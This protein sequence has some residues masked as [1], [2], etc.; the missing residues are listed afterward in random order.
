MKPHNNAAITTS[1]GHIQ[2]LED[3]P[4]E[5]DDFHSHEMISEAL[6]EI[7]Q[8]RRGGLTVGLEGKWGSGKSTIIKILREKLSGD[9]STFF[10]NF[11]AWVH[12]G[13]P[14]RRAFLTGL[15]TNAIDKK[16]F[17]RGDNGGQLTEKW[18]LARE[19][20]SKKIKVHTKSVQP[21][22]SAFGKI[23]FLSLFFMPVGASMLVSAGK[24]LGTT[25]PASN[26]T[27]DKYFL[28]AGIIFTLLP[29]L[30]CFVDWLRSFRSSEKGNSLWAMFYQRGH[31]SELAETSES[32]DSTT[33]EFQKIFELFMSDLLKPTDAKLVIVL[34]NLDRITDEETASVWPVLRSFVD[35]LEYSNSNWFHRLWVIIPYAREGIETESYDTCSQNEPS[36]GEVSKADKEKESASTEKCDPHFLDKIFQIKFFVPAPVLSN[37]RTYLEKLL[38]SAFGANCDATNSHLIYLLLTRHHGFLNP[39]GPRE[40]KN[41]INGMVATA[42]QWKFSVPLEHQAYYS[43]L[44]RDRKIGDLRNALLANKIKLHTDLLGIEI[45]RSLIALE[46]N[47]PLELA[48]QTLYEPEIRSLLSVEGDSSKLANRYDNA[49]FAALFDILI[50][51]ILSENASDDSS[52]FIKN[53]ALL[54][55]DKPCWIS[56]ESK[57]RHLIRQV[58]NSLKR[59]ELFPLGLPSLTE[60]IVAFIQQDH[61]KLAVDSFRAVLAQTWGF[62]GPG[63]VKLF[64]SSSAPI[65]SSHVESAHTLWSNAVVREYVG[66]DFLGSFVLPV[67]GEEY[68]RLYKSLNYDGKLELLDAFDLSGPH[69]DLISRLQNFSKRNEPSESMEHI[70]ILKERGVEIP[71]GV[72][73]VLISRLESTSS[74]ATHDASLLLS[75]LFVESISDLSIEDELKNF[76]M[77]GWAYYYFSVYKLHELGPVDEFSVQLFDAETRIEVLA[78]LLCLLLWCYPLEGA[79]TDLEKKVEG[80]NLFDD[81]L[82]KP[83]KYEEIWLAAASFA[84][85][86]NI[87]EEICK[88]LK[89]FGLSKACSLIEAAEVPL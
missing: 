56:T 6:R 85:Q 81:V 31:L 35:N 80:K 15:I 14:L 13:D 71:L 61:E 63:Q 23:L 47:V 64:S 7:I 30:I 33:I 77:D 18:T 66:A 88:K 39:P 24:S 68:A 78:T 26:S 37:W 28:M 29:I 70:E 69:K 17:Y 42:L 48:A 12:Q 50:G 67:D 38:K 21:I 75:Y 83:E 79:R 45:E 3:I 51:E 74:A 11:D 65:N 87:L 20:L 62:F 34:D 72:Y 5:Q 58:A 8:G 89:Y 4:A 73:K 1:P 84:R 16:S 10:F 43:I 40:I 44:K 27:V 53:L 54:F 82:N 41:V 57:R 36:M 52:L 55:A 76:A 9:K 60:S 59:I 19:Q 32:L 25:N 2:I 46:C 49:G 22:V 86:H